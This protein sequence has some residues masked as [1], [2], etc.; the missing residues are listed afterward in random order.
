MK[1]L[2]I[3][4]EENLQKDAKANGFNVISGDEHHGLKIKDEE[5]FRK[6]HVDDVDAVLVGFD[7]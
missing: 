4:G 3:I 1:T 5:E 7:P 2:Y 6:M